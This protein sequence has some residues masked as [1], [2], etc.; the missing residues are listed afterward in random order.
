MIDMPNKSYQDGIIE[1]EIKAIASMA[2]DNKGRLDNHSQRLRIL[3]RV[4]WIIFGFGVMLNFWPK[5]QTILGN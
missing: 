2:A 4:I 1:G 5:L 3:E